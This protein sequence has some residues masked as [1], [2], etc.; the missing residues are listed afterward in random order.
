MITKEYCIKMWQGI[1]DECDKQVT[2]YKEL[3]KKAKT[4]LKKLNDSHLECTNCENNLKKNYNDIIITCNK[5]ITTWKK[6]KEKAQKAQK[7]CNLLK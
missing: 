6:Q 5:S 4:N 3:N 2:K 1:I 7:N